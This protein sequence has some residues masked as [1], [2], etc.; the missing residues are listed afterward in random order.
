MSTSVCR[1]L[2]EIN[3]SEQGAFAQQQKETHDLA[4]FF[5]H[6]RLAIKLKSEYYTLR[7]V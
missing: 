1:L 2:K 7:R 6:K 3:E 5:C 4:I